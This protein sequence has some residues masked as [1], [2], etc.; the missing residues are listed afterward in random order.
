MK[1]IILLLLVVACAL[2]SAAFAGTWTGYLVDS[3]CYASE[4]SNVSFIDGSPLVNS[5]RGYQIRVCSPDAGTTKFALIDN[6]GQRLKLDASGN[7]EAACLVRQAGGKSYRPIMVTGEK[8]D[9]TVMV[10]SISPI[11]TP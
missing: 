5:D 8:N 6:D 4:Q 9:H 10:D 3:K 2:S 1:R 7:A 11:D